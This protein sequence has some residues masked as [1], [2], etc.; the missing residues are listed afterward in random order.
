MNLEDI[1]LNEISLSQ[2]EKY[3]KYRFHLYEVVNDQ[4]SQK[5]KVEFYRWGLGGQVVGMGSYCLIGTEFQFC[6]MKR[7]LEMDKGDGHT[8][9]WTVHLKQFI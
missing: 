5:Q 9:I 1:M 4:T 6:E 3:W 2:K 8:T 7:I